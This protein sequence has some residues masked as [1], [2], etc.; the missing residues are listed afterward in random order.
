MAKTTV[1]ER[2]RNF[3]AESRGL[4]P[5]AA[6]TLL[7][8]LGL[9]CAWQTW[10]I[11]D[12]DGAK[13]RLHGAQD[14]AVRSLQGEIA[15]ERG[16]IVEAVAGVDPAADRDTL[17]AQLHRAL[18][19]AS[20][21]EVYSGSLDEVVHADYR[22]FGYAKAAQLLAAQT[23]EGQTLMQT[24]AD[25][26]A[27]QLTL[28]VPL[29][30]PAKPQAWVWLAF[31]FTALQQRFES[32]RVP[33]G[34]LEL[35]QEDDRNDRFLLESGSDHS[36]REATGKPVPGSA[37]SVVA[38][39]P[40]AFIVLPRSAWLAGLLALLGI[41]GGG[42]LLWR[43]NRQ[44][45]EVAT[46]EPEE[47]I[48]SNVFENKSETVA[49][50]SARPAPAPAPVAVAVDPT[51][52]RA[53]DVRG[54]VG[55]TLTVE[56]ARLLG[57]SIGTVMREKGLREIVVGRDGRLSGPELAGALS[58]GLRA[59]GI[60]VIDVGAVP[61]PVVYYAA[62]RFNTGSGVAVTGSHNPPDYNGFKI[63]VGGETLSEGAIQ[64]LYRRIAENRLESDGQG[65]VRHVDVVPDYIERITSDV[66]A[67]RRLKI[68]VDCGN[69]IPGAVAPQVL[70]GIGCDV[71]PLYC[72]VDGTFPNHHPDPS[73]PHNLEDLI[74]AVKQTG[75]D[76][77]VAFDGDGDR[78]GVVTREGEIVFPDRT[79][80]LFARDVLSRQPGA[81]IIY[82][83]KCTGHL[84]G[85]ILDAGGSPLMWRTGHSLIKA[86]M[87]ETQAELAGEM[88]GH[89]FFKERWYGF[90]DGIYAGARLLE[91]LAG[92]LEER[93]PEQIFA[94]C[95]KGVST[96]ELKIEM[97]EGEH[98]RFIEKF[99]Q[100]ATFGDATLTTIDGVRADWPDGWGLVR[101]SNTTP[102]LV[103]RFDADNAVALKRIQDV[104]REQ[105]F[106]VDKTLKLPF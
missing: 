91:I 58:D 22:Q 54:I 63:V 105:L 59:A 65:S 25:G 101:P 66:Q 53:Y 92:D 62:Y 1:S 64:D 30:V 36:Q 20:R 45:A 43:R 74:M 39:P 6:G 15:I 76:L 17:I 102:I 103:L 90:D 24:V 80:M 23:A 85:Q 47:P 12:E 5:L 87:R 56:V 27:R 49:P 32:I 57:Q 70:E 100:S 106:A 75:A 7:I 4:L 21:I 68:V 40:E 33:N 96:P 98:Y 84:R 99:R 9:L 83:V 67:E 52:F 13:Q 10:L 16:K 51:I 37:F 44:P 71:I 38:A 28:V 42:Y 2:A 19:Q 93:T 69:G 97:T 8:L 50:V 60:D 41:G 94:T 81:T 26:A 86:K 55:K 48:L 31:P 73:D 78:L 72:E 104:F 14:E 82:D 18:P 29:G 77:G 88:S 34:R 89:F 11:A 3:G 35:H 95:P 46:P 61:T 79:L